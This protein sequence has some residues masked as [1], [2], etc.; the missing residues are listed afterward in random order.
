MESSIGM[1]SISDIKARVLEA[2][3]GSQSPG[4]GQLLRQIYERLERLEEFVLDTPEIRECQNFESNSESIRGMLDQFRQ[5]DFDEKSCRKFSRDLS[6]AIESYHKRARC[7]PSSG[8]QSCQT[9]KFI[10]PIGFVKTSLTSA[11]G[12]V[13]K[14]RPISIRFVFDYSDYFIEIA[15]ALILDQRGCYKNLGAEAYI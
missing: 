2:R 1:E 8:P 12:F 10:C 6:T 14:Y 13:I 4:Y 7:V 9:A 15:D 11:R 3:N 5:Q